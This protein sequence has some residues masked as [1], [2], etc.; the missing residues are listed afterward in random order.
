MRLIVQGSEFLDKRA[1]AVGK[2]WS[3]LAEVGETALII[4]GFSEEQATGLFEYLNRA[5]GLACR[6]EDSR[7][8]LGKTPGPGQA[9]LTLGALRDLPA[10]C[11]RRLS[12]PFTA[13]TAASL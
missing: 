7:A 5:F 3:R 2:F 13:P 10:V 9:V 6:Y 1:K 12:M 4:Q 8:R 11:G